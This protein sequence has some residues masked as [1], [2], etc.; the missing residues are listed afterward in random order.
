MDE[1]D[2]IAQGDTARWHPPEYQLRYE[3]VG[4]LT[5]LLNQLSLTLDGPFICIPDFMAEGF[6]NLIRQK[7]QDWSHQPQDLCIRQISLWIYLLMWME[8]IT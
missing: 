7:V 2:A 8:A 3:E 6:S 4:H 5:D 1:E